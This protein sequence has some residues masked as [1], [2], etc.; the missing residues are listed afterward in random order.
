M[1]MQ[2]D[3]IFEAHRVVLIGTFDDILCNAL[4][5]LLRLSKIR[6]ANYTQ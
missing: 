3:T 5:I 4:S 1:L 6:L 2:D